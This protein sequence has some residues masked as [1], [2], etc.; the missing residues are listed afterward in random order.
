MWGLWPIRGECPDD[1]QVTGDRWW[2][3]WHLS[4][5]NWVLSEFWKVV[6][7]T[8]PGLGTGLVLTPGQ[9]QGGGDI[10][11]GGSWPHWSADCNSCPWL[12]DNDLYCI[13]LLIRWMNNQTQD[14]I[15]LYYGGQKRCLKTIAVF[16]HKLL[17]VNG[18]SSRKIFIFK[19]EVEQTIKNK[20]ITK[21][22]ISF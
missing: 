22:S 19:S 12:G 17:N 4:P 8:E 2:W 7:N 1:H 15:V 21:E 10:G 20:S 11:D 3:W 16:W 5:L 9:C 18:L 14:D 13:V 6:V